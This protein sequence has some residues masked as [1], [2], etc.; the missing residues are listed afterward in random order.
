MTEVKIA[1]LD[2]KKL[3][4]QTNAP[5]GHCK[6]AL[7]ATKGDFA[8]A[9]KWLRKKGIAAAGKKSGRDAA[10]GLVGIKL[11]ANS[12][13]IVEV[14]SE[15]DFVAKNQQFQQLVTDIADTYLANLNIADAAALGE[16][17]MANG[18]IVNEHITQNIATIG[19]NIKL[20]RLAKLPQIAGQAVDA[21]ATYIH[22]GVTPEMGKIGV[23]VAL[24]STADPAKLTE[25]GKKIAM[26]IAA[27]KPEALTVEQLPAAI[28]NREKD[29]FR[30]QAK[31]SGKPDNIIE[32]MIEG[33]IRKFY[34]EAVLL[35]QI[36]VMDNKTKVKDFIAATAKELGTEIELVDYIRYQVGEGIEVTKTDFASEVES[37][38]K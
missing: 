27:A 7:E 35:E 12:A 17:N 21:I 28:V 29:I 15:T 4:Q 5:F 22:N 33:R 6:E 25:L 19:E 2:V 36:F 23:L 26:H 18:K 10:D 20:R 37:M 38:V 16:I 31:A 9:E 24:K 3:R 32:K 8:E 14:N 34:E 13:V 1:A 30:E 11:A